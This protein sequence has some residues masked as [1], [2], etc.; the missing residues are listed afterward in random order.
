MWFVSKQWEIIC[1]RRNDQRV[2]IYMKI[3]VHSQTVPKFSEGCPFI[4]M[5]TAWFIVLGWY[6]SIRE[7]HKRNWVKAASI[8]LIFIVWLCKLIQ[9]ILIQLLLHS[10]NV[11]IFSKAWE[12]HSVTGPSTSLF[13][14]S[15]S[16]TKASVSS[17]F[18]QWIQCCFRKLG[19]QMK[20]S[21]L[22]KHL[23]LMESQQAY[24]KIFHSCFYIW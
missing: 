4:I 3:W 9:I 2:P 24:V 11:W 17:S 16:H 6:C 19:D 7:K 23:G 1:K 18:Y 5:Q 22:T 12:N 20:N 10:I 21:L 8:F 13:S 15:I 14:I